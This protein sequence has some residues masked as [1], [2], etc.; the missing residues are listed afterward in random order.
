MSPWSLTEMVRAMP[1]PLD[2]GCGRVLLA[3]RGRGEFVGAHPA[4]HPPQY[5]TRL[6][7]LATTGG[8][9]EGSGE[10]VQPWCGAVEALSVPGTALPG[11]AE[12]SARPA[13]AST[14]W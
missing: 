4:M 12:T 9:Q 1:R 6:A 7:F 13:Q 5:H 14:A 3:T 2:L 10:G 11:K 8:P